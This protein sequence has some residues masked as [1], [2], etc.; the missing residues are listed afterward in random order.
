MA[1]PEMLAE[2]RQKAALRY[3]RHREHLIASRLIT[4]SSRRS[5]INKLKLERGSC[6]DCGIEVEDWNT[7][8][9]AFDHRET[10]T[11]SFSV[12]RGIGRSEETIRTEAGKCDLVCHN[13]HA[14]R[15]FILR[16]HGQW[17]RD[18]QGLEV[19]VGKDQQLSLFE[20]AQH[21]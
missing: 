2:W 6:M 13:C 20:E 12:A 1:S 21:G 5:F 8:V 19:R 9:F 10:E 14:I 4:M 15:T 16:D 11:K 17:I 18:R 3:A 7:A